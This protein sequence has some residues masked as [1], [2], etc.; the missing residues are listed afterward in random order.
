[1][2][3]VILIVATPLRVSQAARARELTA[4]RRRDASAKIREVAGL[5]WN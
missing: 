4:E 2:L 3:R 1:M 5:V